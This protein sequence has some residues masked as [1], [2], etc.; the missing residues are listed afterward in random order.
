[1]T[2]NE[3]KEK[4]KSSDE[5]II[6]I[7]GSGEQASEKLL[8]RIRLEH[9][10]KQ[11]ICITQSQ[12]DELGM[13]LVDNTLLVKPIEPLTFDFPEPYF[14]PI[15]EHKEHKFYDHYYKNKKR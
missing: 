3:I 10:T 15:I 11:V 12:M 14:E 5:T 13:K 6:I 1:M 4:L 7:G 9:P 2:V 8:A